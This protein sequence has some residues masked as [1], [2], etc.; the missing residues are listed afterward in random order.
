MDVRRGQVVKLDRG[1]PLV[2]LDDTDQLLRCEHAT[3]LIKSKG[4]RAV[5]GDEV[6]VEVPE[7]HDNAIIK[8][9]LPRKTSFIRKDPT[10]RTLP[11]VL[12]ANF[13]RVIVAQ[14]LSEVNLRRLVRE[15]VLAFETGAAVTVVLT[16]ADQAEDE[17]ANRQTLEVVREIAGPDVDVVVLSTVGASG[18]G[19]EQLR[20]MLGNGQMA[21]LIGRS[22]VGKSSLVNLLVGAEVQE[23]GEVR[24]TDGKGRHTTVSRE[25]VDLPGGGRVVDMPGIRGLGLW[26]AEAGIRVAFS[27]IVELSEHCRFRDCKHGNEPGCAVRAAVDEGRLPAIRR[28]IYRDLE[29]ELEALRVRRE[30]ARRMRGEKQT[31]KRH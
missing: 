27:D 14:P 25:V 18:Q 15:L 11:Q 28:D 2:K 3:T 10:E 22:G 7:G 16:K 4:D 6:E 19:L 21:V 24:A 31:G 8:T 17:E 13:N 9:I 1:L 30:E 20:S 29:E 5:I 12:A 23:T 26:D